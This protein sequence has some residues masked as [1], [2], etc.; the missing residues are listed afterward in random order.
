[1][2]RLND[3]IQ[4]YIFTRIYGITVGVPFLIKAIDFKLLS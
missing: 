4:F 2:T 3:R 1:M